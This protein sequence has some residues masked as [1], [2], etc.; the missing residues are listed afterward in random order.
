MVKL[1]LR[2]ARRGADTPR[3]KPKGLLTWLRENTLGTLTASG[4][5]ASVVAAFYQHSK[6]SAE[7]NI[8]NNIDAIERANNTFDTIS[9][10]ISEAHALQEV[11]FF[12]YHEAVNSFDIYQNSYLMNLAKKTFVEYETARIDLLKNIDFYIYSTRRNLDWVSDPYRPN[13]SM[14]DGTDQDP[15]SYAR[16]KCA[17][18]CTG[19]ASVPQIDSITHKYEKS[20]IKNNENGV[21]FDIDWNSATHNL[22]VFNYCFR[23]L[24]RSILD[25]RVWAESISNGKM[26]AP[27]PLSASQEKK[28]EQKIDYQTMRLNVFSSRAMAEVA[29]AVE[30]REPPNFFAYY[31]R[32]FFDDLRSAALSGWDAV[33][34]I[35]PSPPVTHER[36]KSDLSACDRAV[37]D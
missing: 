2:P 7:Q 33:T 20:V 18:T 5:I 15:L 10:K 1:R 30:R 8:K 24:H 28:I 27:R 37:T 21:G 13:A 31:I 17:L 16:L 23:D 34:S 12:T 22:I 19:S 35:W 25:A 36:T 9:K 11:L 4:L 29:M 3:P 32:G 6:W 14:Q 26:L